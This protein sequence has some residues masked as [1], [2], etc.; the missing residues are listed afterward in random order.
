MAC[1]YDGGE[2]DHSAALMETGARQ[3]VAAMKSFQ[4]DAVILTIG[5]GPAEEAKARMRLR[6]TNTRCA[7]ISQASRH[8]NLAVAYE[9]AGSSDKAVQQLEQALALDHHGDC[10]PAAGG[11]LHQEERCRRLRNV[12]TITCGNIADAL[13]PKQGG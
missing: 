11:D 7:W 5:F 12:G 8:V 4:D 2:R 3:L 10:L 1:Q 13:C 6:S 9:Q